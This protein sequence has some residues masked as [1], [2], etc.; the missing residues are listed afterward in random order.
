[1]LHPVVRLTVQRDGLKFET[2]AA[3]FAAQHAGRDHAAKQRRTRGARIEREP[4]LVLW[5]GIYV[6]Y[7]KSR[8]ALW[9]NVK[10]AETITTRHFRW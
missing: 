10:P 8:E 6:R 9:P 3:G 2:V 1:V 4:E 7:T 5:A